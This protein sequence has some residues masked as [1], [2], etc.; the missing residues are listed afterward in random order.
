MSVCVNLDS[1]RGGYLNPVQIQTVY[2]VL[3]LGYGWIQIPLPPPFESRVDSNCVSCTEA[4]KWLD[5]NMP[6]PCLS[7]NPAHIYLARLNAAGL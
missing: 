7:L 3:R 6:P 5:S 2:H 1:N 4:G